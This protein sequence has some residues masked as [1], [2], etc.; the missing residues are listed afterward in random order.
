G[1]RKLYQLILDDFHAKKRE[2]TIPELQA[3][4]RRLGIPSDGSAPEMNVLD[5]SNTP[6]GRRQHIT[7]ESEPG[8]E[9]EANLYIPWSP[10]GP[11]C[12]SGRKPAVLLVADHGPY[13][14]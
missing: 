13:F 3:E 11:S 12:P 14:Q 7:L 1:S 8:V 6:E 10:A 9:I 4:L 5:E 2:G